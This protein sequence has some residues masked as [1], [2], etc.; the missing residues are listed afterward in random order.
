MRDLSPVPNDNDVARTMTIQPS[1]ET[2][3]S[4]LMRTLNTA[5][6]VS[7]HTHGFYQYP[8]RFHPDV[9]RAIIL[10]F[11]SAGGWILDPFMGGG[12]SVI[13]ALALGRQIIGSDVNS[14]ANF[15][16]D[17][18]T[19]PLS[20]N[21]TT[22]ILRWAES[23]TE[24]LTQGDVSW[25]PTAGIV[26]LP[27]EAEVFLSGAIEL[28]DNLLSRR[29]RF[30]RAAL[31]RLGQLTI[32]CRQRDDFSRHGLATRLTGLVRDMIDGIGDFVDSCGIA[33]VRK[34]SITGRRILLQRSA[35]GLEGDRHI[36]HLIGRP[37][38]VFTSPPY[39]GVHVLYHRWQHRG[40]RETPAPY[41]IANVVDGAGPAYYCGGGRSKTGVSRYFQ[42]IERAFTS[43][44]R[45][46]HTDGHVVQI[47]GFSNVATQLP[48]YLETMER[49]GFEAVATNVGDVP[50]SRKVANRRWYASIKGDTDSSTEYLLV[51]RIRR[52]RVY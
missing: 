17:V 43:A 44:R 49:A 5:S 28:A 32:D 4:R 29:K 3:T 25:I 12:T 27:R 11:S 42:M 6:R 21:D 40:R 7:G 26:N 50:L 41:W 23:V 30:A 46:M 18:R 45:C 2:T 13:E 9:A 22:E 33:G 39:P 8:A 15:V 14:L 1:H 31:L 36:R 38:L 19:T 24:H 34:N 35:V 48:A 47:I 16:S 51:H 10:D 37:S 52:T 20:P